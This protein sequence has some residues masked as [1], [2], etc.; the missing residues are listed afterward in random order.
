MKNKRL[1]LLDPLGY[2]SI[3][4]RYYIFFFLLQDVKANIETNY[5]PAIFLILTTEDRKLIRTINDPAPINSKQKLLIP[6]IN[7]LIKRLLENMEKPESL[8]L[9][10]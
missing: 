5:R 6:A 8:K 4:C 2:Q 1:Y 3:Y 9:K 10:K 7:D